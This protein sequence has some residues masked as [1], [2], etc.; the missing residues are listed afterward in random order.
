MAG[1][2]EGEV[3]VITGG[4]S[5]IG[6]STAEL[7]ADEG[8]DIVIADLQDGAETVAAVQARGREATFVETDTSKEAPCEALA[9]AAIEAFGKID[10]LVAAAG[11]SNWRYLSP[12]GRSRCSPPT[13]PASF[14]DERPGG[15][16]G[17]G[18]RRQPHGGDAF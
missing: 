12:E 1:K 9:E 5:G 7:F 14:P 10:V 18:D 16:V 2:L 17:E 4:A 11:I 6:R 3:A 15:V 8:A 13:P